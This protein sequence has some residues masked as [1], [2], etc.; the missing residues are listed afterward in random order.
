[1]TTVPIKVRTG[2][3]DTEG[4]PQEEG[5]RH[6]RDAATSPG[7]PGAPEAGRGSKDPP[8]EPQEGAQP[9]PAWISDSDAPS[10]AVWDRLLRQQLGTNSPPTGPD[11]P[12]QW[13][14]SLIL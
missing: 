3:T 10:L 13:T 5:R 7:T 8:L 6:G 14:M 2:G 12:C 11:S 4:K 1:M 9:C